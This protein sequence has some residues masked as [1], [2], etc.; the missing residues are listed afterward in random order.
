MIETELNERSIGVT[1]G[2]L[3]KSRTTALAIGQSKVEAIKAALSSGYLDVFLTS[4]DT[5]REIAE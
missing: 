2:Q 5:A 3:K 1:L 4:L